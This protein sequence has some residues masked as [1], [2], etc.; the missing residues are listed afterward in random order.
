MI[1]ARYTDSDRTP[2]VVWHTE[3]ISIQGWSHVGLH[4]SKSW[5][6][7][8]AP[9]DQQ[10]RA[11]PRGLDMCLSGQSPNR[12]TPCYCLRASLLFTEATR[13]IKA[14][15]KH[16]HSLPDYWA[17]KQT[18]PRQKFW[19]TY[20]WGAHPQYTKYTQSPRA[21]SPWKWGTSEMR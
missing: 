13:C 11:W 20:P 14:G 12:E 21:P 5:S 19:K 6:A 7:G 15:S 8:L 17:W 16:V 9:G 10:H 18:L 4:C 3:L 2:L 1:W